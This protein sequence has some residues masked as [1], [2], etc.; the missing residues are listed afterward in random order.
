MSDSLQGRTDTWTQIEIEDLCELANQ[1]S[2]FLGVRVRTK[3]GGAT[4][5]L[6]VEECP[7]CLHFH[8]GRVSGPPHF[9]WAR[10]ET[11]QPYGF[12][13]GELSPLRTRRAGLVDRPSAARAQECTKAGPLLSGRGLRGL[14]VR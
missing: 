5:T 12:P 13:V 4:D 2:L 14:E 9:V 6:M 10:G 11:L 3:L 7:G 8:S 1:N